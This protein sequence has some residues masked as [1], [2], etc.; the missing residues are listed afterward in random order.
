MV[1]D[2][3]FVVLEGFLRGDDLPVACSELDFVVR[4]SGKKLGDRSVNQ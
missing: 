4:D 3:T 2:A 1:V